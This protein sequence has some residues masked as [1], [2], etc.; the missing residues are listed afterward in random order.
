MPVTFQGL[1]VLIR[2]FD[3]RHLW[4]PHLLHHFDDWHTSVPLPL[5]LYGLGHHQEAPRRFYSRVANKMAIGRHTPQ[6]EGSALAKASSPT[7]RYYA[8][9]LISS[10]GRRWYAAFPSTCTYH[11]GRENP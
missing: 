9:P 7:D 8:C 11:Y 4:H 6:P 5:A 1:S 3:V 10:T 2:Q